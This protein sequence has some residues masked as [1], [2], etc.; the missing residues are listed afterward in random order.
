VLGLGASASLTRELIQSAYRKSVRAKHPDLH[1]G[2]RI[3]MAT[4]NAARD[5]LLRE[6]Q[7]REMDEATALAAKIRAEH[8]AVKEGM[9]HV[10]KH[11]VEAGERLLQVKAR[12]RHGDFTPFVRKH[13]RLPMRTAQ[14]YMRLAATWATVRDLEK[15]ATFARLTGRALSA[16]AG[17]ERTKD[18]G[19][20]P[21]P[22]SHSRTEEEKNAQPTEQETTAKQQTHEPRKHYVVESSPEEPP[23]D[24]MYIDR[25]ESIIDRIFKAIEELS[26]RDLTL[27]QIDRMR[28]FFQLLEVIAAKHARAA[29]GN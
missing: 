20:G 6:V 19:A 8:A 23:L 5:A 13:C 25:T 1:P 16:M 7:R 11:A 26:P 29:R 9:G 22:R 21:T 17:R 10:L 2:S 27:N 12:L 24:R 15:D 28:H 18:V 4:L 3:N 14:H